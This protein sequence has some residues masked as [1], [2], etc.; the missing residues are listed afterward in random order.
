MSHQSLSQQQT[1]ARAI[2]RLLF[3]T[4]RPLP[5]SYK[6]ILLLHTITRQTPQPRLVNPTASASRIYKLQAILN[7][8]TRPASP[9]S[10][11][12]LGP[13]KMSLL[14]LLV[15]R[16][17]QEDARPSKQSS[18][19]STVEMPRSVRNF[20]QLV[21]TCPPEDGDNSFAKPQAL[22]QACDFQ[23]ASH[24]PLCQPFLCDFRKTQPTCL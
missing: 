20:P 24:P 23:L 17:P 16:Q 4:Y 19:P 2:G 7:A 18:E 3:L 11:S 21:F 1:R 8:P 12:D 22:Q 15:P 5:P 10:R 6:Q 9:K 13:S 14:D